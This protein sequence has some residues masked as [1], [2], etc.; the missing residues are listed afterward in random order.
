MLTC[1]RSIISSKN[2]PF[3]ELQ[4][5]LSKSIPISIL[6]LLFL[7][8]VFLSPVSASEITVLLYISH[9]RGIFRLQIINI[10][11]FFF[12]RYLVEEIKKREG[13]KLLMEVSNCRIVLVILSLNSDEGGNFLICY[14]SLVF[15][16]QT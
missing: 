14:I 5:Y 11:D 10:I 16:L 8:L 12:K 4:K 7:N 6:V 15:V 1:E 13:F 9:V 2:I 3:L